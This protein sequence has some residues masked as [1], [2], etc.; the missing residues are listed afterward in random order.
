[1]ARA[2]NPNICMDCERLMEDTSPVEAAHAEEEARP[3]ESLPEFSPER[4][5]EVSRGE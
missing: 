4:Q 1:M 2:A 5:V 3:A